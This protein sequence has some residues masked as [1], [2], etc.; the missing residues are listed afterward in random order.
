MIYIVDIDGTILTSPPSEY[1][2]SVPIIER[3]E[4]INALF[5][6]GHTIIYW[7]ARGAQSGVDWTHFTADQLKRFGCKYTELWMG[8]PHYDFWIDDK[9][10]N[11]EL[12]FN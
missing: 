10:T 11:A 6:S 3:I 8:K 4:K 9:A 5:D 7:T 2:Q 12:F 1:T